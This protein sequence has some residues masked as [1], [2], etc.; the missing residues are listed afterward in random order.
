MKHAK[1]TRTVRIATRKQDKTYQTTRKQ[2]ESKQKESNFLLSNNAHGRLHAHDL[3]STFI[4]NHVGL[5]VM[6]RQSTGVDSLSSRITH[7]RNDFN[8]FVLPRNSALEQS[9]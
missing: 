4:H 5:P 8:V 7:D 6:R 3:P 9:A 1:A 2:H